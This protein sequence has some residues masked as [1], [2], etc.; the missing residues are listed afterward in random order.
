MYSICSLT[1]LII[2]GKLFL[3]RQKEPSSMKFAFRANWIDHNERENMAKVGMLLISES[4]N[5]EGKF[6]NRRI[7]DEKNNRYINDYFRWSNASTWRA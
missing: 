4:Q 1:I 3:R 2:A 6:E 7:N 5:Y